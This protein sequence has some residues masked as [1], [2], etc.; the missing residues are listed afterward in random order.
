MKARRI[1][2][3]FEWSDP[4]TNSVSV[5]LAL[6]GYGVTTTLRITS[7]TKP[8]QS[9]SIPDFFGAYS[10][11]AAVVGLLLPK[12]FLLAYRAV[13]YARPRPGGLTFDG[14]LCQRLRHSFEVDRNRIA[15]A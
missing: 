4:S 12:V 6:I 15:N 3:R 1:P 9:P 14:E 5:L 13:N 10:F 7:A 2:I 11:I 8:D